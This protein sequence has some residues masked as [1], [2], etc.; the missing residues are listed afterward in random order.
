MEKRG[1]M[2]RPL[3]I[4]QDGRLEVSEVTHADPVQKTRGQKDEYSSNHACSLFGSGSHADHN[5]RWRG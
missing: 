2:S 5:W 1:V 3:R 4:P